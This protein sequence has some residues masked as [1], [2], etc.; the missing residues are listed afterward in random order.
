MPVAVYAHTGSTDVSGWTNGFNHPLHGL[1]HIL[2]MLAVGVWAAQ[3]RGSAIWQLPLAF[4]G[5]MS[6]GGLVG[7]AG[8]LGAGRGNDDSAFRGRFRGAGC[9]QEFVFA[10]GS[11][12]LSW[13]FLHFFMAMHTGRK[14]PHRPVSSHLLWDSWRRRYCC[15]APV[16]LLPN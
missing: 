2:T 11:V 9:S 14:Y 10:P 13:C 6:I 3:L 4:V 7:V 16:L 12:C 1:D 15:M 8:L 5:V